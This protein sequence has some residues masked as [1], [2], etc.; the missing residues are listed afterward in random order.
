MN[1]VFLNTPLRLFPKTTP[2]TKYSKESEEKDTKEAS[3]NRRV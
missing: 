3:L 2:A 1:I